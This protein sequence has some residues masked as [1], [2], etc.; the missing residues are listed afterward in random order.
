MVWSE[1]TVAS[2]YI[3]YWYESVTKVYAIKILQDEIVRPIWSSQIYVAYYIPVCGQIKE[4]TR[5]YM[6]VIPEVITR[7][8]T[9][10]HWLPYKMNI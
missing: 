7:Y 1:K 8:Y 10:H 2:D 4:T 6:L 5:V 3:K 9:S